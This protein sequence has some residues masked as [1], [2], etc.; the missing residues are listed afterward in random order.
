MTQRTIPDRRR[1][2]LSVQLRERRSGFDRRLR[3]PV[4]GFFR[5]RPGWFAAVIVCTIALSAT[6][7]VL[8]LRALGLGAI[9][10][11]PI[12]SSLLD[13]SPVAAV[14]FKGFVT[15]VV[16]STLW[17]MRGCR[18]V[19]LTGLLGLVAYSALIAYQLTNLATLVRR[20]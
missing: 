20:F 19:I 8:T 7:M 3:H 4:L 10:G 12:M 14:C 16:A 2:G 9:E 18:R 5:D 15:L 17:L 6:D 1:S 13:F 11:N